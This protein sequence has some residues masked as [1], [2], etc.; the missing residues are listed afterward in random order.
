MKPAD[1]GAI[2]RLRIL[3]IAPTSFFADYGCHIRILQQTLALQSRGHQ[4]HI[5]TYPTGR[6]APDVSVSR[7]RVWPGLGGLQIGPHP[8]KIP[9]D[10]SLLSH[11]LAFASRWRPDLVFGYLH[12]GALI[13]WLVARRLGIPLTFDFQGSLSGELAGR[14][15]LKSGT[16]PYRA[17]RRIERWIHRRADLTLC[18]SAHAA[19]SLGESNDERVQLLHDCVDTGVFDPLR[20]AESDRAAL[21]VRLG[22]P[23]G[24]TLIVYL[25]LLGEHQGIPHL[26]S[27]AAHWPADA[28]DVHFL[29][30]GY[31]EVEK[32]RR[33][34]QQSGADGRMTFSGMVPYEEAPL[35]L[36]LGDVAVAPKV[37]DSEGHGKLLNYM[38]MELPT[39]AFDTPASREYLGELGWYAEPGDAEALARRLA[40]LVSC[41]GRAAIGRAL[42][43]RARERFSCGA[44]G[45]AL[46]SALFSLA[47][48]PVAG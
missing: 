37:S 23:E 25:G 40:E 9:L 7:G 13:G 38:A 12:E 33:L 5:L 28:P 24:T 16:P 1:E 3:S 14:G 4:V 21:R 10:V 30:M 22:I 42:R 2:P 48:V 43:R 44:V 26:L 17:V 45:G 39:V 18:S 35:Y 41:E 27:A 36:S 8:A 6:D 15:W 29:V 19:N 32:Y 46:E 11:S 20:F 47:R 31:P 34:A